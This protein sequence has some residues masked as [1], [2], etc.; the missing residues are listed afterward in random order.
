MRRILFLET[1]TGYGGS[2]RCLLNLLGALD[3][4]Q[5]APIVAAYGEGTAIRQIQALGVEVHIIKRTATPAPRN[6]V[7]FIL[8]I[9]CY[10]INCALSLLQLIK[11]KRV[12]LVHLNNDLHSSIAG[13]MA[14]KLTGRPVVAHLRLTRTPTR[15]ERL[16]GGQ[17][18]QL[19]ALTQHALAFYR[20]FWPDQAM[21]MIYDAVGACKGHPQ[22]VPGLREELNLSAD[23]KLVVLIA[24]C[25]PGK[26]YEEFLQAAALVRE[27]HP[28]AR[29]VIIGNGAGGNPE[30][31][32]GLRGLAGTLGLDGGVSWLGWRE[33]VPQ[34]L[35]EAQIV[36]Q[37]S[38]T[39]PEG[40][41][42]VLL[43][44][45]ACGVPLVA[46]DLATSREALDSGA[47]GL[48]VRPGDA[49]ELARAI[50]RLLENHNTG[51]ELVAAARRRAETV[52]S[53]EEHAARFGELYRQLLRSESVVQPVKTAAVLRA[54]RTSDVY[55]HS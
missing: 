8:Q 42:H 48:L 55:D 16:L 11:T 44:A 29:F 27:E 10:E 4:Q 54:R 26:G 1:S 53:L 47:G 43:Q 38:S 12:D 7:E 19:V 36:V 34:I 51:V 5:Y 40:L 50:A 9:C 37:A 6:Y 49:H 15:L 41:S 35:H 22:R 46:T 30:Y 20:K 3:R 17:V 39:F 21:T 23:Q 45:M 14:A 28:E 13:L 25:V 33:D 24:R 52:F 2:G 31:E 18:N 32:R